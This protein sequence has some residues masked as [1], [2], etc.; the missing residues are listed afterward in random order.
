MIAKRIDRKGSGNSFKRTAAYIVNEKNGGQGD[1]VDWKLAEYVLD[2]EHAGEKVASHRITNCVS[3]ELGWAVKECIALGMQNKRST[4]DKS[5]HLV[6]SF[7]EGERPTDDQMID[8]EDHLVGAI[9][10]QD[11]KRISAVH[12][13]TDNWHLHVAIMTVHPE[14]LRNVT[15]YYDE[16]RLQEACV[17]LEIKH[18]LTRT[19]HSQAPER[20]LNKA[21]E[22][23]AHAGRI[24]FARWVT[25]TVAKPL[26]A[27]V[28]TAQTWQD[29]HQAAASFG[30]VIK[31]RGAGL[32]VT[33]TMANG[34]AVRMKA[35]AVDPALAY[36][37]LTDRLGPYEPPASSIEHPAV[38]QQYS[39][40]PR[41]ASAA[42]WE[43]YQRERV[44]T[45]EARNAAL[46]SLRA[47]HRRY[48]E[49]LQAWHTKRF[50]AARAQHLSPA[51]RTS[52]YRQLKADIVGYRGRQKEREAAERKAL[53]AKYPNLAWS[54]FLVREAGRGDDRAAASLQR[55]V[56]KR[57]DVPT[58]GEA[59]RD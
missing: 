9:G 26:T 28:T 40:Q 20:P 18:G 12:Q 22:M 46:A 57:M 3:D 30:L 7:P 24:S 59:E 38:L 34:K 1:P 47:G 48:S 15:P 45:T 56:S 42:L 52:T 14:T 29:I 6:I 16:F 51:N 36:K 5:Y 39:G 32:I 27:A 31:P 54:E 33:S 49:D 17:E 35:S 19:R 10:L 13:N 41:G 53:K 4:K 50:A 55:T 11:H 23:E 2:S 44:Q 37:V 21:S 43:K 8:I 25:E 58:R